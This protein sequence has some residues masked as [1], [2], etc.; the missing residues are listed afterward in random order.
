MEDLLPGALPSSLFDVLEDDRADF[1]MP[2]ATVSCS[3]E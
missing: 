3:K 2:G 1:E